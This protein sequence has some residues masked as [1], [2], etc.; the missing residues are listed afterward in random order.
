MK[1]K[2]RLISSATVAAGTMFCRAVFAADVA[3][4]PFSEGNDGD[5]AVG[6]T[7]QNA[8][9][10]GTLPGV[11]SQINA[12]TT[13]TAKFLDD[14]PGRY[15]YTNKTWSADA[16]YRSDVF[17]SIQTSWVTNSYPSIISATSVDFADLGARLSELDA[18]TV[19]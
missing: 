3:F 14:V 9:N 15:L 10:P 19:E 11:V 7:L 16:I 17:R 5:S 13:A 4:Y 6:V 12:N 2:Q 18:F 1:T 8:A